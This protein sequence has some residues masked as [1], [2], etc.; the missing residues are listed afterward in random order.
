MLRGLSK[1]GNETFSKYLSPIFP[2]QPAPAKQTDKQ[3]G[4]SP[5]S[6]SVCFAEKG[7]GGTRETNILKTFQRHASVPKLSCTTTT[8]HKCRL[9][10]RTVTFFRKWLVLAAKTAPSANCRL[11][12]VRRRKGEGAAFPHP[13]GR[14]TP[15]SSSPR[16]LLRKLLFLRSGL[17]QDH[18][19]PSLRVQEVLV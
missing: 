2:P 1:E 10:L 13:S 19:N 3:L 14:P 17:F 16:R 8:Q 9:K 12:G 15:F 7:T 18:R 4:Q 6:L 11:K 5:I